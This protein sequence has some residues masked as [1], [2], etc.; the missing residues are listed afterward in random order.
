MIEVDVIVG[1]QY[2]DEG[3]GQVALWF[4]DHVQY[5]A[6]VRVGGENAEHRVTRNDGT[7]KTFHILPA[8]TSAGKGVPVFLAAG[9]TCSVGGLLRE[10]A[11]EPVATPIFIDRN[12]AIITDELRESGV[13]AAKMRGSTFLGVGATMSAKVARA[14]ECITAREAKVAIE[15]PG[16]N[17]RVV[18]VAAQ[19]RVMDRDQPEGGFDA[20]FRVQVEASQGA[21]LSLDH[22]HYPYCTSRNMT[23]PGAISDAGLNHKDVKRVIMVLKAVPTRVPGPS[24]PSAGKELTWEEVCSNAGRPFEEIVQTADEPGAGKGAG[25]VE[26]PFALS[27]EEIEYAAGLVGPT[28]IVLTFI[29]WYDYTCHRARQ[30]RHLSPKV[31]SL[32]RSIEEA[33]GAPVIQVRTGPEYHDIVYMRGGGV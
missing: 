14:G 17:I 13:G 5:D 22:G 25:G 4:A 29:D 3:K 21:M 11:N 26:R 12:A 31:M 6:L 30:K 33:A 18:N 16:A 20:P 32:I 19:L 1:G 10:A 7:K 15:V 8:G 27:F 23:A 9:M 24:G 28:S 2:G